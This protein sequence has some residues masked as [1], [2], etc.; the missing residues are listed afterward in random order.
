MAITLP[1]SFAPKT[2]ARASEVMANFNAL[3][4]AVEGVGAAASGA[5][6]YQAGVIASTD[7]VVSG[8]EVTAASTGRV[9]LTAGGAAWLP[10]PS[11]SLVRTF[12]PEGEVL[13]AVKPPA[14]PAPGGYMAVGIEITASGSEAAASVVSGVEKVSAAE[15]LAAPPAVTAGKL[16]LFDL[17][18]LNTAGAY[19]NANG[20]DRRRWARGALARIKRTSG[21]ITLPDETVAPL[22]ATNLALRVECSG[23]PVRLRLIGRLG[24]TE[25]V[26]K[27]G[28]RADGSAV[29]GT[30]DG[31]LRFFGTT[32]VATQV[33]SP[34]GLEYVYTPSVG[35]HLFQPTGFKTGFTAAVLGTAEVPLI[36]MV[37]EVVSAFANNG[38]A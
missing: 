36:F 28:F 31:L 30:G 12:T 3:R 25:A 17:I 15:A 33:F 4:E 38:T 9:T 37:E 1:F 8:K 2:L 23:A 5:D 16:R 32:G 21:T 29:D 19:S 7:W 22:D 14:L 11:G 20:R 24:S 13:K 18:L 10:G 27:L 34:I 6:V 26:A 35:S